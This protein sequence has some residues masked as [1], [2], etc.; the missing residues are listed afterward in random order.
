MYIF[1]MAV[2]WHSPH[3]DLAQ[4]RG[5]IS[6]HA[7]PKMSQEAYLNSVGSSSS[8]YNLSEK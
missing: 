5:A 1:E 7:N 8:V 2:A 4:K 3:Q 6:R